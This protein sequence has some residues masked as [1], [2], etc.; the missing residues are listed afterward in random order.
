MPASMA[1]FESMPFC[2][3]NSRTSS[4]IFIEQKFGPH[5]ELGKE[6]LNGWAVAINEV[7]VPSGELENTFLAEGDRVLFVQATQG[8]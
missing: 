2:L 7:V 6:D 1:S 3:A 4:L 5:I 8:G